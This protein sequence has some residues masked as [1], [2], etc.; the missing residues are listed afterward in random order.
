MRP[1]RPR[2]TVFLHSRYAPLLTHAGLVGLTALMLTLLVWAPFWVAFVPC[3]IIS[4]RVGVLLHEYIHGIPFRRYDQNLLVLSAWDGLFL[5]CGLMELF[6]GTHLAHHRWLNTERD[7]GF[8]TARGSRPRG[9]VLG[10]VW[11]LEGIQH[12]KYLLESFQGRHPYVRPRR[13]AASAAQSLLWVGLW[14]WVGA[15]EVVAKLLTLVVYNTLVP[16]SLRGAVEH[17]SHIGDPAF[18]NEY[19]VVIPLFNLNRHIHH[20]EA[21]WV[22]WYLLEF[23]TANPLGTR[24][25]LTHWY[26]AY[27]KRDYTLMQPMRLDPLGPSGRLPRSAP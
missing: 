3:A 8:Q 22:P 2:L 9:Q 13:M 12:L 19:T 20:H 23:R 4:H 25:Y 17:H 5:L 1:V 14:V 11:L 26:H 7:P 6:R 18:A 15:P 10:V 24:H 21:P 16:I 27:V